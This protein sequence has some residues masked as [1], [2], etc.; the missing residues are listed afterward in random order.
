MISTGELRKGITL[1]LEGQLYQVIDYHHIKMGRGS[2]QVRLKLRDIK[3]GHTIE[4]TVQAGERFPRARLD[5]SNVQ[6]LYREG[7]L[8]YFMDTAS[9]E[10]TPLNS[11]QLGDA[12][13]YLKEG[14]TLDVLTYQGEPVGVELPTAVELKVVETG[15]SFKGDTATAGNKPATLETGL[16]IQVPMFISSGDMVKVDT[17]S[18]EY[19]ERA[20]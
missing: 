10:Q 19:L 20:G 6:Y 11:A 9:Y 15:P 4:R 1:E 5:R 18:G 3:G 2:A 14:M 13:N 7:D 12:V 17:R 8:Y 16:V